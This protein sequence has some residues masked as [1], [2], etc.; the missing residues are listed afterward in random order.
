MSIQQ[1]SVISPYSVLLTAI[2]VSMIVFGIILTVMGLLGRVKSIGFTFNNKYTFVIGGIVLVA[3]AIGLLFVYYEPSTI[4][5]GSGYMDVHF[6]GYSPDLPIPFL[7]GDKN[8]TS[9]EVAN[10]FVDQ[11]GS[12][13]FTLDK[14]SG[15]NLGTVNVGS[16]KLGN[17]ATAYIAS[18]NSTDL[19]IQLTNGQ[20]IILGNSNTETLAAS[21]SQNVYQL[22][23]P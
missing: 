15:L 17:G 19:I 8:I 14:Q 13:D 1:F 20:Y 5:V 12:G 2:V 22:K 6:S 3:V 4:T 9:N 23:T 7:S 16:F 21:F 10:A 18:N 11:I